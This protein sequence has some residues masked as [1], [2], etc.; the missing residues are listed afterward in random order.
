MKAFAIVVLLT[1]AVLN[2][3]LSSTVHGRPLAFVAIT[4]LGVGGVWAVLRGIWWLWALSLGLCPVC[5][6]LLRPEQEVSF[7][8]ILAREL[9]RRAISRSGRDVLY[10]IPPRKEEA[11]WQAPKGCQYEC[12]ALPHATLEILTPADAP[13]GKLIYQIHGGGYVEALTNARR[14]VGAR[15]AKLCGCAVAMLDYR[16]APEYTYP[17]A[18]TDA[19][20]GWNELLRQDYRPEDIVLA[21][22]SAGGN[23]LLALTMQLRDA[24]HPLP[25][26]ILAMAPLGDFGARGA[27]HQFNLYRDAVLGKSENYLPL[28]E[29][30]LPQFVYAGSADVDDPYLSPVC[31]S[32]QGFP[33]ILLQTGTH[34]L[35][36]SD[37]LSIARS[38]RQAGCA[39]EVV[40]SSGMVHAFQ[41]G[42]AFIR[43]C[44]EAWKKNQQWLCHWLYKEYKTVKT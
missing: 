5:T 17:T 16:I 35:L 8:G 26:A 29:E 7:G 21:G 11:P 18:L 33:P 43:E 19:R 1:A 3:W 10:G 15:Y 24:G 9:T 36:L 30:A 13:P 39:V 14:N 38:A 44:R 20:D 42:P 34:D 41:F 37:T 4:L 12:V 23:L 22:D 2:L 25:C 28:T 27:S 31:G 32:F 40:L 6:L